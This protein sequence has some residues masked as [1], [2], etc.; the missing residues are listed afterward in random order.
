[1]LGNEV[2]KVIDEQKSSGSYKVPW[3]AE[4]VTSGIYFYTLTTGSYKET[5]KMI[6]LK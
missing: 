4:G 6:L 3:N 1:V 5:K 2:A